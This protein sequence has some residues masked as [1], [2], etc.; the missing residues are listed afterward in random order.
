MDWSM[1]ELL[2]D[3]V[4][5]GA[6]D[7][8]LRPG[9]YPGFRL[10]GKLKPQEAYGRITPEITDHLVHQVLEE[11]QLARFREEK[12]LDFSYAIKDCARF[13]INVLTQRG[14][15]GVVVRTIPDKIPTAEELDLPEV[16]LDLALKPRGLVLVTGATGSGKSTT[17]AAM[18]DHV[19]EN[20]EG[21]ILT[22]ED[23]IEFI[24]PDKKCF[25]TQRQVG[26]D[27]KS[28]AEALRRALRQDPDVILIGE[29]RDLE[30]I[31]LAISAAE[32]GHLVFG[33]LHTTSAISTVD[34]IL[35]VFPP[36]QQAQ[37]R[38]Q[39][40]GTLQ[41][42]ISQCLIRKNGGGRVAAHEVLVATDACRAQ[43]REGKTAQMFNLL[44]TGSKSGMC[45][46][47]SRL[48]ELVN[49]GQITLEDAMGKANRPLEVEKHARPG[50]AP[51]P[52]PR[53]APTAAPAAKP[54]PAAAPAARPAPA[55]SDR[56]RS[57]AFAKPDASTPERPQPRQAVPAGDANGQPDRAATSRKDLDDLFAGMQPKKNRD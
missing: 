43:I 5:K 4:S 34:R 3:M 39:L 24:H 32:T 52:A 16:C 23:P 26:R 33:T 19:N 38:V 40:S 8:H 49:Q 36:D 17:L 13:R 9:N 30:T 29:M 1:T 51:A 56:P 57:A 15:T 12:D 55:A 27:T 11:A 48:I 37:V 6:S 22:M 50:S 44:Q 45:T 47:E 41:G 18:V 31:A 54:A 10:D 35:D 20:E 2:K 42:V 28:F 7:L 21:H 14:S 25:V 53:P 46:L